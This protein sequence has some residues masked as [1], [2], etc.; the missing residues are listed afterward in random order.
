MR[1]AF[2][3][4]LLALIVV[5]LAG[6]AKAFTG[7]LSVS[8]NPVAVGGLITVEGCGFPTEVTVGIVTPTYRGT[9]AVATS[10]GC[11]ELGWVA[12]SGVGIYEFSVYERHDHGGSIRLELLNR[13]ETVAG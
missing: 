12:D 10:A 2:V 6:G 13:A 9:T 1:V 11:F 7:S 8:P 3:V 4:G 5:P